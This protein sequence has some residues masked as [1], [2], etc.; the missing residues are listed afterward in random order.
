VEII[1]RSTDYGLRALVYI[2]STGRA[3]PVQ[4][5]EIASAEGLSE[6]YIQKIL[7][8]LDEAGIAA[9]RRGPAGGFSLARQPD[10]I[11]LLQVME[12]LQGPVAINKCLLG[13]DACPNSDRCKVRSRWGGMQ[14]QLVGFFNSITLADLLE[15]SEEAAGLLHPVQTSGTKGE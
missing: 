10:E 6:E 13:K 7:R 2:A 8:A 4:A 15:D 1:R 3:E 5:S 14:A 9:A 12:A 11:T